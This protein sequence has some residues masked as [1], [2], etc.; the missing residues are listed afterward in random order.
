[1]VQVLFQNYYYGNSI[2]IFFVVCKKI[3]PCDTVLNT[4]I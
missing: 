3:I 1:M 4:N 2:T